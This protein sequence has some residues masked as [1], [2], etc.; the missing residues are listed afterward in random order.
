MTLILK[1]VQSTI[2]IGKRLKEIHGKMQPNTF[3]PCALS[4]FRTDFILKIVIRIT[5]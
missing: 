5:K 4:L 2:M 1:G 3:M